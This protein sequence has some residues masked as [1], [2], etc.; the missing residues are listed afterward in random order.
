LII[1]IL[2]ATNEAMAQQKAYEA[3]WIAYPT[4]SVTDYGVYH[5]RKTIN[6]DKIPEKLVVHVSADNRY[7]LLVNG[8]RVCY[9]PAK[10]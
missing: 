5:F 10:G 4:A 6:V 3:P 8:E 2:L 1:A 7:N 9:G